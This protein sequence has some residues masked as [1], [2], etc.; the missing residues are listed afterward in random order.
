MSTISQYMQQN[1]RDCDDLF[2]RAEASA[3]DNDWDNAASHWSKFVAAMEQ[4]LRMEEEVLFPAFEAQTGQ[5]QGPT[6][7][8]RMEHEQMRAL[9]GEISA[10]LDAR[11]QQRF[12]GLAESLMVLMQQHNMKEEQMLYPMTDRALPDAASVLTQMQ[13]LGSP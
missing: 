7:V 5:T 3:A 6:M 1:H 12:L 8:M 10:C 2:A 11:N 9:L 4:H 13:N